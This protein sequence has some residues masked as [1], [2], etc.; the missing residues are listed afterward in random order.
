MT[1]EESTSAQS[2]GSMTD[3]MDRVREAVDQFCRAA[4]PQDEFFL[5]TFAEQPRLASDFTTAPEDLQSALLFTQPKGR[6]ALLDAHARTPL[7]G[8]NLM[9]Q[10][11]TLEELDGL[12]R[13]RQPSL[14]RASRMNREVHVRNLCGSG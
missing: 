6:T 12:G 9:G 4:N 7:K 8:P 3:K 1:Q 14:D 5:I 13:R 10:R 2:S 11:V